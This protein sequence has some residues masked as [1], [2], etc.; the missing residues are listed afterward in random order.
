[1]KIESLMLVHLG[2]HV[3]VFILIKTQLVALWKFLNKRQMGGTPCSTCKEITCEIPTSKAIGNV[4]LN[5]VMVQPP[6]TLILLMVHFNRSSEY[7]CSKSDMIATEQIFIYSL[8]AW[9]KDV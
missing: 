3:C 1:M 6:E 9:S 5:H 4:G 7:D 8:I 2:V